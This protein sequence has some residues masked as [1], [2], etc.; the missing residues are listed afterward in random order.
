M[1]HINSVTLADVTVSRMSVGNRT[2]QNCH[3][4]LCWK[5]FSWFVSLSLSLCH[6][7]SLIP[8]VNRPIIYEMC[9]ARHCWL[10]MYFWVLFICLNVKSLRLRD[11]S[12][13]H[14][15]I[16]TKF[17]LFYLSENWW[18]P[19]LIN[20]FNL[21]WLWVKEWNLKEWIYTMT[22]SQQTHFTKCMWIVT[23]ERIGKC[24]QWNPQQSCH[25]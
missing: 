3:N 16:I 22:M 4:S 8:N 11:W 1:L 21:Y 9:K 6:H 17:I 19:C 5:H 14:Y 13:N 15:K 23:D 18:K 10:H 25:M 24:S 12:F 20:C 7:F 2:H